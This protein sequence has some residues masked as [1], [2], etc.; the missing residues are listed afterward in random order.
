MKAMTYLAIGIAGTIAYQRI[1]DNRMMFM[2]E[3]KR[4][5]RNSNQSMKKIKEIF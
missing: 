3:M 5:M 4:M 2:K 1:S